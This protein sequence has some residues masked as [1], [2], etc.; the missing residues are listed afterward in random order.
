MAATI[1][2]GIAAESR[3]LNAQQDANADAFRLPAQ[4]ATAGSVP[5]FCV[6]TSVRKKR[7]RRRRSRA[8][9]ISVVL[10]VAFI[11]AV[12]QESVTTVVD[13][14]H[15]LLCSRRDLVACVAPLLLAPVP[16]SL[17]VLPFIRRRGRSFI[18]GELVW[19]FFTVEKNPGPPK[20]LYCDVPTT[21][22]HITSSGH[23]FRQWY[24][25][26]PTAPLCFVESN[27]QWTCRFCRGQVNAGEIVS[28][29]ELEK[30]K[31]AVEAER[32]ELLRNECSQ[33]SVVCC[34]TLQFLSADEAATHCQ[35]CLR[36]VLLRRRQYEEV[37]QVFSAITTADLDSALNIESSRGGYPSTK[38]KSCEGTCTPTNADKHLR[39]LCQRVVFAADGKTGLC[40]ACHMV[41]NSAASCGAHCCDEEPKLELRS[42]GTYKCS[43]CNN[44]TFAKYDDVKIHVTDAAHIGAAAIQMKPERPVDF[45]YALDAASI[46][47]ICVKCGK[48]FARSARI[49]HYRGHSEHCNMP[50]RAEQVDGSTVR[51]TR[52]ACCNNATYDWKNY[53]VHAKD[54]AAAIL[55]PKDFAYASD[56][57]TSAAVCLRCGLQFDSGPS[58]V[59]NHRRHSAACTAPGLGRQLPSAELVDG[60]NTLQCLRSECCGNKTYNWYTYAQHVMDVSMATF[61]HKHIVYESSDKF[62]RSLCLS[63]GMC[64]GPRWMAQNN[65]R[66]AE[67]CVEDM[68]SVTTDRTT[69]T[70]RKICCVNTPDFDSAASLIEHFAA[71]HNSVPADAAA[72]YLIRD[73]QG[74]CVCRLCGT[75]LR[76]LAEARCHIRMHRNWVRHAPHCIT[77]AGVFRC[78]ACDENGIDGLQALVDHV[79][80]V[81]H[82]VR[83]ADRLLLKPVLDNAELERGLVTRCVVCNLSMPADGVDAH[84]SGP[85]HVINS[86]LFVQGKSAHVHFFRSDGNQLVQ[87]LQCNTGYFS[88]ASL[89]SH[90]KGRQHHDSTRTVKDDAQWTLEDKVLQWTQPEK[91]FEAFVEE[92]NK[93]QLR[94]AERLAANMEEASRK[95]KLVAYARAN[96]ESA[97]RALQATK[98]G[99]GP[100]HGIAEAQRFLDSS[101]Q[102]PMDRQES[103]NKFGLKYPS[104]EELRRQAD[105]FDDMAEPDVPLGCAACGFRCVAT[106]YIDA[107]LRHCINYKVCPEKI[108][109]W[110]QRCVYNPYTKQPSKVRAWESVQIKEIPFHLFEHECQSEDNPSTSTVYHLNRELVR[111]DDVTSAVTVPLCEKCHRREVRPI[112]DA[113]NADNTVVPGEARRQARARE[114]REKDSY[115]YKDGME[116]GR[117]RIIC[118]DE[119]GQ[120]VNTLEYLPEL[121]EA[122][123]AAISRVAQFETLTE[124]MVKRDRANVFTRNIICMPVDNE[125]AHNVLPVMES[126][127]KAQMVVRFVG[128]SAVE[129]FS[130]GPTFKEGKTLGL[131]AANALH[132]YYWLIFL[133]RW[134]KQYQDVTLLPFDAKKWT[135]TL[136]KPTIEDDQSLDKAAAMD[137]VVE[138]NR[139]DGDDKA[140]TGG[141]GDASEASGDDGPDLHHDLDSDPS[142]NPG[143]IFDDSYAMPMG[144]GMGMTAKFSENRAIVEHAKK[145]RK[146]G[147]LVGAAASRGSD[148][149]EQGSA[150][151][152]SA[153]PRSDDSEFDVDSSAGLWSFVSEI[154]SA[155]TAASVSLRSD[156]NDNAATSPPSKTSR[157]REDTPPPPL[158]GLQIPTDSV[159]PLDSD[160][161]RDFFEARNKAGRQFQRP[162][163]LATAA[164]EP[165][166]VTPDVV[167]AAP[168]T[169]DRNTANAGVSAGGAASARG[170]A[171]EMVREVKHEPINEYTQNDLVLGGGFPHLFKVFSEKASCR[172]KGPLKHE[173]LRHV[174]MN[175]DQRFATSAQFAFLA[176]NQMRRR[177]I[178]D[179]FRKGVKTEVRALQRLVNNPALDD[180][181]KAYETDRSNPVAR[182][183]VEHV[184]ACVNFIAASASY[185]D[186]ARRSKLTNLLALYYFHGMPT[187]HVTASM[188]AN[189]S[190]VAF[191]LMLGKN[192]NDAL[193]AM[194][195]MTPAERMSMLLANPV[196][197]E[198][199]FDLWNKARYK[200]LF[201]IDGV[202]NADR[203]SGGMGCRTGRTLGA[204]PG[205]AAGQMKSMFAAIEPHANLTSHTHEVC[206]GSFL[207][208]TLQTSPL[209]EV[210]SYLD[211]LVST[212]PVPESGTPPPKDYRPSLDK[213]RGDGDRVEHFVTHRWMGHETHIDKCFDGT[214]HNFV[215]CKTKNPEEDTA[216]SRRQCVTCR[217]GMPSAEV[218]ATGAYVPSTMDKAAKKEMSLW[219]VFEQRYPEDAKKFQRIKQG[220]SASAARLETLLKGSVCWFGGV[221]MQQLDAI[222]GFDDAYDMDGDPDVIGY[223][224]GYGDGNDF[225]LLPKREKRST[226]PDFCPAQV[227][228]T[229]SSCTKAFIGG[230]GF[231]SRAVFL[232]LVK[233][234][235]NKGHTSLNLSYPAV[236]HSKR[237]NSADE[238][239]AEVGE[240]TEMS[241]QTIARLSAIRVAN[242]TMRR[243]E[244]SRQ[245][246][247][248]HLLGRDAEY[249]TERFVKVDAQALLETVGVFNAEKRSESGDFVQVAD[250]TSVVN[251]NDFYLHRGPELRWMSLWLWR[252]VVGIE[253]ARG[254][255][256]ESDGDAEEAR[257]ETAA[258]EADDVN[259]NNGADV[260]A[261]AA[262][263]D[264]DDDGEAVT[265]APLPVRNQPPAKKALPRFPFFVAPLGGQVPKGCPYEKFHQRLTQK[266]AVPMPIYVITWPSCV[267]ARYVE[268]QRM[269]D[270]RK[271]ADEIERSRRHAHVPRMEKYD[272]RGIYKSHGLESS[273]SDEGSEDD[274]ERSETPFK[275][276]DVDTTVGTVDVDDAPAA[277]VSEKASALGTKLQRKLRKRAEKLV[278]LRRRRRRHAMY[279]LALFRPIS[280]G[281][282]LSWEVAD[283]QNFLRDLVNVATGA[284]TKDPAFPL[285]QKHAITM[286]RIIANVREGLVRVSGGVHNVFRHSEAD[287]RGVHSARSVATGRDDAARFLAAETQASP[288]AASAA[289]QKMEDRFVL[290]REHADGV[291]ARLHREQHGKNIKNSERVA[292]AVE[293]LGALLD[294]LG[295]TT[296]VEDVEVITKEE[297]DIRIAA[298]NTAAGNLNHGPFFE[299]AEDEEDNDDDGSMHTAASDVGTSASTELT[300]KELTVRV[301]AVLNKR[302][303]QLNGEQQAA[304]H[305]IVKAAVF[306][307]GTGVLLHG[308]PG[309]G[310]S[311]TTLAVM[312]ALDAVDPGRTK[313]VAPTGVAMVNL[314]RK[315]RSNVEVTTLM[316]SAGI[317]VSA[318]GRHA[319]NHDFTE[320]GAG[321]ARGTWRRRWYGKYTVIIDEIS[322]VSQELLYMLDTILRHAPLTMGAKPCDDQPFGGRTVIA[323]GDFIQLPPVS[324]GVQRGTPLFRRVLDEAQQLNIDS[325]RCVTL[326][327]QCRAAGAGTKDDFHRSVLLRLRDP[328]Q[329]ESALRDIVSG[330]YYRILSTNDADNDVVKAALT[331]VSTILVATNAVRTAFSEMMARWLSKS[332]L[333]KISIGGSKSSDFQYLHSKDKVA[334]CRVAKDRDNGVVNG[335]G[336]DEVCLVVDTKQ[337]KQEVLLRIQQCKASERWDTRKIIDLTDFGDQ[338]VGVLCSPHATTAT[339]QR[340]LY[341]FG[342]NDDAT[343]RKRKEDDVDELSAFPL[344]LQCGFSYT[345][346]KVQSATMDIPVVLDLNQPGNGL[347]LNQV[348]VAVSRARDPDKIFLLPQRTRAKNDKQDWQHV[349]KLRPDPRVIE[350]I[351]LMENES[352]PRD[353]LGRI[354]RPAMTEEEEEQ[355]E[356]LQ[357]WRRAAD[358]DRQTAATSGDALKP[359]KKAKPKKAAGR[360]GIMAG[361]P[362]VAAAAP[363]TSAVLSTRKRGR[364]GTPPAPPG[365]CTSPIAAP[366]TGEASDFI[367]ET[368]DVDLP[369]P[370]DQ[371]GVH[372][373]ANTQ[374]YAIAPLRLILHVCAD[375]FLSHTEPS[376]LLLPLFAAMFDP[377]ATARSRGIDV[378]R[379]TSA[380]YAQQ[381]MNAIAQNAS[382]EFL[383]WLFATEKRLQDL[384]STVEVYRRRHAGTNAIVQVSTPVGFFGPIPVVLHDG[385]DIRLSHFVSDAGRA[386]QAEYIIAPEICSCQGLACNFILGSDYFCF[387]DN[388]NHRVL[389]VSEFGNDAAADEF[390]KGQH[391][392]S[393]CKFKRH[394][395]S[396]R[397]R[398]WREEHGG[399]QQLIQKYLDGDGVVRHRKE[400]DR[401]LRCQACDMCVTR[402]ESLTSAVFNVA[403]KFCNGI[404]RVLSYRHYHPTSKFL[405]FSVPRKTISGIQRAH[406]EVEETIDAETVDG[407]KLQYELRGIVQFL[408]A[409]NA[410]HY[411]S[412]ARRATGHWTL[413]NDARRPIAKTAFPPNA[414]SAEFLYERSDAAVPLTEVGPPVV[415]SS[416]LAS[417]SEPVLPL[418]AA[419][420]A[421]ALLPLLTFMK[422]EEI[423]AKAASTKVECNDV[424]D[425]Q[426][427]I[428]MGKCIDLDAE[429]IPDVTCD[430]R[431]LQK[432]SPIEECIDLDAE[433]TQDVTSDSRPQPG[434]AV[435][436]GSRDV[437]T[438]RGY[439]LKESDLTSLNG[440]SW[441]TEAVVAL[442]LMQR[443]LTIPGVSVQMS[444]YVR[445][446]LSDKNPEKTKLWR[447]IASCNLVL[448]PYLLST[449][450]VAEDRLQKRGQLHDKRTSASRGVH[451]VLLVFSWPLC[452]VWIINSSWKSCEDLMKAF[453]DRV[454]M[455]VERCLAAGTKWHIGLVESTQQSDDFSCGVFTCANGE[456]VALSQPLPDIDPAAF[457]AR[458][459]NDFGKLLDREVSADAASAAAAIPAGLATSSAMITATSTASRKRGAD[460]TDADSAQAPPPRPAD[461]SATLQALAPTAPQ[462]KKTT[463]QAQPTM[464]QFLRKQPPTSK[465]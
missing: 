307:R 383:F 202:N 63:C 431:P 90:L 304:V 409:D 193:G 8:A 455:F 317:F 67:A 238:A 461:V 313:A 234:L 83:V 329:C 87:C 359:G 215:A 337:T 106:K 132:V 365:V 221:T 459:R 6:A 458:M 157:E 376:H 309:T 316:S 177:E 443:T 347:S 213:Q 424:V 207:N 119:E 426:K 147:G 398:M 249:A 416:A 208:E 95:D 414:L 403:T 154:R 269:D 385:V 55:R 158:I 137:V 100:S 201:Q 252:A 367:A 287:F 346:H 420:G 275:D 264:D 230:S 358:S 386:D 182:H 289:R 153:P 85:Q 77:G 331:R 66:H 371:T 407:Q 245:M 344:E 199:S 369:G 210:V 108:K 389:G 255:K 50:G 203:G 288:E 139:V 381:R 175:F 464:E 38:C 136:V 165:P 460:R 15:L 342:R 444:S 34:P 320:G 276:E 440:N 31:T 222:P 113:A 452:Q 41:F 355:R 256:N 7:R 104:A 235:T 413:W 428:L 298:T 292:L 74:L 242:Y 437:L 425:V 98:R 196:A 21:S 415:T 362:V 205:C 115:A 324:T 142:Q 145:L 168:S 9:L 323:V 441:L 174:L 285:G 332:P 185:S 173:F 211:Q 102:A 239:A 363:A 58:N 279:M 33:R 315:N 62:A 218:P 170:A 57:A 250:V 39:E 22:K 261:L 73:R 253:R 52:D 258:E 326:T 267:E 197:A 86:V 353:E 457:R 124:I 388:C 44:A 233:Y 16:V 127:Y 30:H 101:A 72:A 404:V 299:D 226:V 184:A 60:D 27:A 277:T 328:A 290:Q 191:Q 268:L 111:I 5:S 26:N 149:E 150:A 166:A 325:F 81:D 103:K 171:T 356:A 217:M 36:W 51:C 227:R 260:D 220:G 112:I 372:N 109:E 395:E 446:C 439:S 417:G 251:E 434:D 59:A 61:Q 366:A 402:Y 198:V 396:C 164:A 53:A 37:R 117:Q 128:K 308:P 336:L 2:D 412:W 99:G 163:T 10:A 84:C 343:R 4:E 375:K 65:V 280:V 23:R 348:V 281:E 400:G 438:I 228:A 361:K 223:P 448:C 125:Q 436:S 312:E 212:C 190:V 335:V 172:L 54:V 387:D 282:E 257:D 411:V 291:A 181:F 391:G 246:A 318:L 129:T 445:R 243:S 110:K 144:K 286:L 143:I 161:G 418:D 422:Y 319:H 114:Q 176:S 390:F 162:A 302:P 352:T 130:G 405:W 12:A 378:A 240:K 421:D 194:K 216:Q 219:E 397:L 107:E 120:P 394:M 188:K 140:A 79:E 462:P 97:R 75:S 167:G 427:R 341:L 263:L 294:K 305:A 96:V 306:Q 155:L 379:T 152:S 18:D 92:T 28:H 169:R 11:C 133:V 334:M 300:D 91:V 262:P 123:I 364:S 393:I 148:G 296:H 17:M 56:D 314:R 447:D 68:Q 24:V 293:Q 49:S 156:S 370:L 453:I 70:C 248:R 266:A 48:Q 43:V 430:S 25:E 429:D 423:K 180:M 232:Y 189:D 131:Y 42:D 159:S 442:W 254:A 40:M 200:H 105:A 408:G 64:Q 321:S 187:V 465:E 241:P 432:R 272:D 327:T 78:R 225:V 350:F 340:R 224:S 46:A 146:E 406:L 274:K 236:M 19:R 303:I 94:K 283:W 192:R 450:L 301:Q 141:S 401:E 116:F 463:K 454:L 231:L 333:V 89:A 237:L 178:V 284:G 273:S 357:A 259:A 449:D 32:Q 271:M 195:K 451:H 354:V 121:S 351:S 330:K 47:A 118:L 419:G 338:T 270:V 410:G 247:I 265:A 186:A 214:F 311:E 88:L 71:R 138:A 209:N 392:I 244:L 435:P 82:T 1:T 456:A 360:G 134:N 206:W 382:D 278:H 310:K 322:M 93:A 433:D 374:C 29:L 204:A 3:E 160:E 76:T 297:A 14:D 345:I 13:D 380:L 151:G 384:F 179:Y 135:E 122:S 183:F 295:P 45:A 20:C 126:Q 229:R 368:Q 80:H 69:Y 339:G 349:L 35:R 399:S 377:Q 373:V